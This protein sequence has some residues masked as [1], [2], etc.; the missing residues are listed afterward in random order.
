MIITTRLFL[1]VII[2][3]SFPN[4]VTS[5]FLKW[6]QTRVVIGIGSGGGGLQR[7]VPPNSRSEGQCPL[8]FITVSLFMM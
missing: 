6:K 7:H 1:Y 8:I 4:V 5:F 3:L 2:L